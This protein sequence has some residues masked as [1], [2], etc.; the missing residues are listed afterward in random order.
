MSRDLEQEFTAAVTKVIEE[1]TGGDPAG[2][3]TN[4]P[5]DPG[6]LTR[7]GVSLRAHP[8]ID[9]QNLSKEA[10]IAIYKSEYWAPLLPYNLSPQLLRLAFECS[11]NEGPGKTKAF[12]A[13]S[14]GQVDYFMTERVMDYVANKNWAIYGRGWVRRLIKEM[15]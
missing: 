7:W 10:A 9:V 13:A 14:K 8:T 6:G 5:K 12:L 1:E 11:I 15:L 4:D 2:G 3:L